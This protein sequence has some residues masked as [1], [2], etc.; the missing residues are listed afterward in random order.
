MASTAASSGCN[1]PISS[2]SSFSTHDWIS[3][4]RLRSIIRVQ[5]FRMDVTLSADGS[6]VA[7]PGGDALDC[8]AD[9]SFRLRCAI[10]LL[11]MQLQGE[12]C[13]C[14]YVE[15]RG[16]DRAAMHAKRERETDGVKPAA[17]Q[18][19]RKVPV[20]RG[21][22]G[23]SGSLRPVGRRDHRA[24]RLAAHSEKS[25]PPPLIPRGAELRTL[26][27]V[28][29]QL[30][31]GFQSHLRETENQK[32]LERVFQLQGKDSAPARLRLCRYHVSVCHAVARSATLG[33]FNNPGASTF[34]DDDSPVMRAGTNPDVDVHLR[35]PY[36]VGVNR[37][38]RQRQCSKRGS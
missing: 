15:L 12:L 32:R 29:A 35:H 22:A 11:A 1:P 24:R 13:A 27:H 4:A 10:E 23:G 33:P 2:R 30:K 8:G 6:G 34:F 14:R 17:S 37:C 26:A 36:R 9:A 7:E 16:T 21:C 20:D 28:P 25:A 3:N 38:N 19:E 5:H 31:Q 18:K